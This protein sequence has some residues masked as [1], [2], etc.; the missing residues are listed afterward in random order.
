MRVTKHSGEEA[1]G[2]KRAEDAK[3]VVLG[4]LEEASRLVSN[5]VER[6]RRFCK[7]AYSFLCS[8]FSEQTED[9]LLE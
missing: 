8:R 9:V 7:R 2:E 5:L 4:L 3:L 6:I 1:A